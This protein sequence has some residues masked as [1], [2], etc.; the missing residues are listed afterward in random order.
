MNMRIHLPAGPV[1]S[2]RGRPPAASVPIRPPFSTAHAAEIPNQRLILLRVLRTRSVPQQ[3]Q[4]FVATHSP[5]TAAPS[6]WPSQRRQVQVLVG[7]RR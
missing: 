5:S 6:G 1:V 7:W 4:D 2:A 3:H